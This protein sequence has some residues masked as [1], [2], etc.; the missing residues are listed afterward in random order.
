MK[1]RA[2]VGAMGKTARLRAPHALCRIFGSHAAAVHQ[3][4][5]VDP[6]LADFVARQDRAGIHFLAL[7]VSFGLPDRRADLCRLAV[8]LRTVERVK[9]LHHILGHRPPAGL[10]GIFGRLAAAPMP[11]ESYRRLAELMKEPSARKVLAHA[12][13][14]TRQMLDGLAHLPPTLRM[15]HLARIAGRAETRERL[16]YAL[17]AIRHK[18]PDLGELALRASLNAVREADDISRWLDHLL[19]RLSFPAPPWEGD[20]L[21]RPILDRSDLRETAK[22]FNNCL[23]EHHLLD[24]VLGRKFFYVW[25]NDEPCV[26]EICPD[27]LIGWRTGEIE[28]VD[29]AAPSP[30]TRADIVTRLAANGIIDFGGHGTGVWD[31]FL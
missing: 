4:I 13:R 26:V 31:E 8:M 23:A 25:E 22:R 20:R 11:S 10:A 21:L 27:D 1:E 29:N 3:L 28:G 18:R 17:A 2:L 30:G 15:P 9:L 6:G 12:R 7:A 19:S 5:A 24:A 16:D 14:I